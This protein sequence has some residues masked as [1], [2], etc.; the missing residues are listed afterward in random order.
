MRRCLLLVT[1]LLQP[2]SANAAEM[3]NATGR[4]VQIPDHPTRVLPAG[5]PAAVLLGALGPTSQLD[6][7]ILYRLRRVPGCRAQ[8][9]FFRPCRC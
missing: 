8:S 3:H 4:S 2:L 6:G 5:P 9:R 7:R 1:M